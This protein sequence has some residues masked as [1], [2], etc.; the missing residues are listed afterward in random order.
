[1]CRSKW[2]CKHTLLI[3]L[4]VRPESKSS[5]GQGDLEQQTDSLAT[6]HANKCEDLPA[7]LDSL[8]KAQVT[9][10][11]GLRIIKNRK[12]T[13]DCTSLCDVWLLNLDQR[14]LS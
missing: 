14:K 9:G 1:M 7:W 2:L 12:T 6:S 3:H 4:G 11:L 13:R 5:D 8:K 10:V